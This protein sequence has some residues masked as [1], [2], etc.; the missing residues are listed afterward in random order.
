MTLYCIFLQHA[1]PRCNELGY[2]IRFVSTLARAVWFLG[3]MILLG[4]ITPMILTLQLGMMRF[5]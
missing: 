3:L 5:G 1:L 2:A 4:L